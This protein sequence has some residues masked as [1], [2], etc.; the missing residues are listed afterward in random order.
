MG[1][2]QL[3]YVAAGSLQHDWM[4]QVIEDALRYGWHVDWPAF[5]VINPEDLYAS[6][7]NG[8]IDYLVATYPDEYERG[9]N[10]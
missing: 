1:K 6:D 4:R 7:V 10:G 8:A 9:P 3:Q 5:H 2:R